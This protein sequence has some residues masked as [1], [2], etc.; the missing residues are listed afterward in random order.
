MLG[1]KT[2]LLKMTRL[3]YIL[4]S[5]SLSNVVK[6]ISIKPGYRSD[7]SAVIKEIKFNSFTREHD[8]WKFINSL[9]HND[10]YVKKSKTNYTTCKDWLRLPKS[11]Q[12]YFFAWIS[13]AAN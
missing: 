12:K 6:S 1:R 11:F 4:I 3:N 13:Y 10:A 9:L 7:H 5:E 8:I 2:N